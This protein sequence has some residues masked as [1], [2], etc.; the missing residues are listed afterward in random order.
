[1]KTSSLEAEFINEYVN[2]NEY[3]NNEVCKH[4]K[5]TVSEEKL[6]FKTQL[7]FKLSTLKNIPL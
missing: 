2:T 5:I 4:F 7:R 6:L 1:M 3:F